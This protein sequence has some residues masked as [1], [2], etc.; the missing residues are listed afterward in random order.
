MLWFVNAA[1]F[2]VHYMVLIFPTAVIGMS[3]EFG[4]SYGEMIP[5]ATITMLAF[6]LL[7]LPV[8]MLVN[9][10]G[11]ARLL[12]I[13]FLLIG[14]ASISVAFA[15]S[16]LSLAVTL[17]ALGAA[18]AMYHPVGLTLVA[19]VSHRLGRDLAVNGVW[20]NLGS[21][22]AAVITASLTQVLGWRFAFIVPGVAAVGFG[23]AYLIV[24][25]P[26]KAADKAGPPPQAAETVP[27]AR[28]YHALASV[29]AAI[30]AGGITYNIVT[31]ALPKMVEEFLGSGQP[32]WAAGALT[33]LIFVCGAIMQLA[34]G[35]LIDRYTLTV[36]FILLS[37]L[38]LGGLLMAWA[39][40]GPLVLVGLAITMAAIYG[41]VVVDDAIVARFIPGKRRG[42]AY[43]ASYALGFAASALAIPLMG[44]LHAQGAGFTPVLALTAACGVVLLACAVGFSLA[45]NQR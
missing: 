17:L 35:R 3:G 12:A 6:G 20:G 1:H 21:A 13:Y 25:R 40:T 44:Y 31:V 9:P 36:L 27:V 24:H 39:F 30:L 15:G 22:L 4:L 5:L 18:A 38:Q 42:L 14:F 45:V 11:P 43:G 7:S 8:G 33:T 23:I 34:A 28:P 32:L 16:Y 29:I 10:V 19:S 26:A 2:L 37:A 41:Q